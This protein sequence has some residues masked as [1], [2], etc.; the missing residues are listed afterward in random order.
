MKT[1]IICLCFI[2]LFITACSQTEENSLETNYRQGY[3]GVDINLLAPHDSVYENTEPLLELEISNLGAYDIE[4]GEFSV[5]GFNSKYLELLEDETIS[6]IP[7]NENMFLGKNVLNPSGS[8]HPFYFRL[9]TKLI[10]FGK[11]LHQENFFLLANYNY[12]TELITNICLN[13][14]QYNLAGANCEVPREPIRLNGQGSP[15]AITQ[16]Q[17][18]ITPGSNPKVDFI[19]TLENKGQGKISQAVLEQAKLGHLPLN[20]ERREIKF[21]ENEYQIQEHILICSQE[22]KEFPSY[23]TTLNLEF[24]FNYQLE[25]HHQLNIKSRGTGL[26]S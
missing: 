5:T 16:I 20:C 7:K 26:V 13:T 4:Q 10:P 12:K 8:T 17:E 9:K 14:N 15:L 2:L 24:S 11:D 1:K 3:Q 25:Q 22:I 6:L 23:E 19:F 18:I 21:D